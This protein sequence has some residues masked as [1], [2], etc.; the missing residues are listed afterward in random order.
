MAFV[1][2]KIFGTTADKNTSGFGRYGIIP[3]R[4]TT[5]REDRHLEPSGRRGNCNPDAFH[6]G[7]G[8][9]EFGRAWKAKSILTGAA[10][11][12]VRGDT[13][14]DETTIDWDNAGGRE[15]KILSSKNFLSSRWKISPNPSP[16]VPSN[17]VTVSVPVIDN[18][19]V[20]IFGFL[21]GVSDDITIN[22]STTMRQEY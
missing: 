14:K 13:I 6:P 3:Q 19:P 9:A 17:V 8:M 16:S 12:A 21:P 1:I 22:R 10:R 18:F 2:L 20:T 5:G 15:E 11:E 7:I 4:S